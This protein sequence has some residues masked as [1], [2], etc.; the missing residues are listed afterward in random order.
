MLINKLLPL[1][2]LVS[3]PAFSAFNEPENEQ[4]K[5]INNNENIKLLA[6]V[7]NVEN[8]KSL[9]EEYFPERKEKFS[10]MISS[11]E[12]YAERKCKFHTYDSENTDAE[13][14]NFSSCM[15]NEYKELN[16]Y[17]ESVLSMP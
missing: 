17:L 10:L 9:I 6:E 4:L 13:F 12:E 5:A 1:I 3:I 8:N 14:A 7:K 11:W 15:T 16:T 2:M